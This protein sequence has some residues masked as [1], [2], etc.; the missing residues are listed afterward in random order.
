[1]EAQR[2]TC[3]SM[4]GFGQ[5]K[6]E[7]ALGQILIEIRTV[8]HRFSEWN[9]RLPREL[10]AL[11]SE[12]RSYLAEFIHRGRGDLFV[13]VESS[14]AAGTCVEVDWT[15]VDALHQAYLDALERYGVKSA[16]CG[17]AVRD[18][19]AWPDVVRVAKRTVDFQQLRSVV[20]D[21]LESATTELMQT[22]RREGM[23]IA[24]DMETKTRELQD[25]VEQIKLESPEVA[26]AGSE[27]LRQKVL[28][29][30]ENLDESRFLTEMVLWMDKVSIDEELVR[31]ASHLD[32]FQSALS[33]VGPVG[34]RLDFLVQEMNR[35]VNTIGSKANSLV[36]SKYVVDAKVIIEQ[37]REQ[38]QNVE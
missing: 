14:V 35:E 10:H 34:R 31:L 7:S 23:R 5:A 9:L 11:D 17:Q 20:F 33:A 37:L 6:L 15:A 36:I 24:A 32:E 30:T 21:A 2:L 8:N 28:E 25:I 27:R 19:L 29:V 3:F 12:I 22:R 1:M 18:W 4:T 38:A 13:T 26:R 16:D